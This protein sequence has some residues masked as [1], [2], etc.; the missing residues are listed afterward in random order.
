MSTNA[1]HPPSIRSRLTSALLVWSLLWGLAVGAAIW[2]AVAHEVDELLDDTLQASAQVLAALAV[3][4]QE[5]RTPEPAVAVKDPPVDRVAWQ[6]VSADGRLLVRSAAAPDEPWHLR[7]RLGFSDSPGW[8]LYGR[9]AGSDGRVLYLGQSL[10]ERREARLEVALSAVLAAIAVGVLGHLWLRRRMD[11]EMQPLQAL[12][13]RLRAW[14]PETAGHRAS[15]LGPAA[16]AELAPV[17]DALES[18]AARLASRL[19]NERA[20]SAHAAHALRTPLAG[21][22][23][24]LAVALRECPPELRSR[25][26]RIREGAGRLQAVIAALLGLFRAGA[27]S[28]RTP[29]ALATLMARLPTARLQV[30]VQ[31]GA[32]VEADADLLAAALANLL[33]NA[34]RHGARQVWIDAPAPERL[35]VRDDGPGVDPQRLR[36]LQAALAAQQYDGVTGLGLML[37]DR[38]A[39]AHGGRLRLPEVERGFAVEIDLGEAAAGCDGPRNDATPPAATAPGDGTDGPAGNHRHSSRPR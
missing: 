37:A 30:H 7:P 3:L 4:G 15:A 33:D 29:V 9:P 18:L 31:T 16:R 1:P 2:L 25:L 28:R 20:F 17:H 14:S 27:E 38:V 32:T 22:D 34:Q 12:A 24:Q 26:Q 5:R 13:Q 21:L 36:D 8:R 35:R 23:A 11:K 10:G 39:R 19:A 6:L